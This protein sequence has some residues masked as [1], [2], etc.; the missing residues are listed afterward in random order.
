MDEGLISE[1]ATAARRTKTDRSKLVRVAIR[2]YLAA[3]QV[4]AWEEGDIRAYQ[5]KPLLRADIE[6]WQKARIWPEK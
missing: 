5:R 4:R 6:L 3:S 2:R 1:L